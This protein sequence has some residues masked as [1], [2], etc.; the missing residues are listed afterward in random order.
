[1]DS[2]EALCPPGFFCRSRYCPRPPASG[3]RRRDRPGH[4]G[5]ACLVERVRRLAHRQDRR[6][7]RNVRV[8]Y[9]GRRLFAVGSRPVL[10]AVSRHARPGAGARAIPTAWNGDCLSCGT[11]VWCRA[12]D[13]SAQNGGRPN[14]A[15]RLPGRRDRRIARPARV[16]SIQSHCRRCH[17]RLVSCW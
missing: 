4:S 6:S 17:R 8:V 15:S 2:V 1:M 3:R 13:T 7:P 9:G 11:A 16:L 14:A 12:V 10:S 5:R